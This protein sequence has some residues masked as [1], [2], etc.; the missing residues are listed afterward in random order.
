MT[1]NVLEWTVFTLSAALI[2][3]CAGLI[4]YQHVAGGQ[5]AP[6][7][8]VAIGET[9]QTTGGY[10]VGFDVRNDGDTSAEEVTIEATL[11]W[12]GGEE[13][14]EATIAYVPYRS[15][16]RAWIVFSRAP[17]TGNLTARVLGYR[18]P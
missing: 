4:L 15:H 18:E 3:T 9:A 14:G 13:T 17:G 1:K 5:S 12:P 16:R 10:A 6:S 7:I 2:L 11:R 8:A